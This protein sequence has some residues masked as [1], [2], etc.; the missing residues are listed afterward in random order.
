M[1]PE[2]GRQAMRVSI[3]HKEKS[4][5]FFK[6]TSYIEVET[7]VTFSE[8]ELAIIQQRN[9]EH[10]VLLERDAPSVI[11]YRYPNKEAVGLAF[12]LT[13]DRLVEAARRG[14]PDAYI[15]DDPI[16]ARVYEEKLTDAL[17][18]LKGMIEIAATVAPK[19]TF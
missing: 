15:C 8:E 13:V 10:Y 18:Y 1:L 9:L 12:N 6:Q 17:K 5:G 2:N 3:E 19:K 16:H 7:I 4:T 11:A 14:R